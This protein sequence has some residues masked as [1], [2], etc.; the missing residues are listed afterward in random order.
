MCFQSIIGGLQGKRA[1]GMRSSREC[2]RWN[3]YGI[4]MTFLWGDAV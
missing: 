3:L 4:F 2:S 1:C